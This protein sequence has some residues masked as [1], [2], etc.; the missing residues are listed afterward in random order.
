M[1]KLIF[2]QL[3]LITSIVILVLIHKKSKSEYTINNHVK[4]GKL[5]KAI[6]LLII[7]FLINNILIIRS[8]KNNLYDL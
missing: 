3:S 5:N 1:A 2:L 4:F 7:C 6:L 8:K